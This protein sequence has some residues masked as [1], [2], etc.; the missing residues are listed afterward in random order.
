MDCSE[1]YQTIQDVRQEQIKS[2]AP[3]H[4]KDCENLDIEIEDN[5]FHCLPRFKGD[6]TRYGE[7]D[8]FCYCK[9]TDD[10]CPVEKKDCIIFREKLNKL[11]FQK[12]S[13]C[14]DFLDIKEI[15][16]FECNKECL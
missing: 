9:K 13:E 16:N 15:E 7:K 12:C 10:L 11:P 6:K 5:S 14:L 4:C 8:I 1:A 3:C 2:F